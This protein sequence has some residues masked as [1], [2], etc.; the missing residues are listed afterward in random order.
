MNK[1]ELKAK[2]AERRQKLRTLKNERR[3]VRGVVLAILARR[4]DEQERRAIEERWGRV[5]ASIIHVLTW[6][7]VPKAV[8]ELLT[9]PELWSEIFKEVF[10][11]PPEAGNEDNDPRWN[12]LLM[13]GEADYRAYRLVALHDR[14]EARKTWFRRLALYLTKRRQAPQTDPAL[15]VHQSS[16]AV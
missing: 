4:K 11:S 15:T 16:S 13:K 3:R 8:D 9:D 7:K 1:D 10:R 2:I 14:L 12:T 5:R 6:R